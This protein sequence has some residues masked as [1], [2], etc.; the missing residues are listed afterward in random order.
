MDQGLIL[1]TTFLIDL[2][3]EVSRGSP[4]P[5][6]AFLQ[7]HSEVPL[8]ITFTVSGELAA[9][10]APTDRHKWERFVA[11]F[12]VLECTDAVA[13]TYGQACRYLQAHGLLIGANDLWI[14][15]TAI[16]N[17]KGLVTANEREYT[18]VPGL[19]V[20]SYRPSQRRR[21]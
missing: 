5:A 16:T 17:G 3:R 9:G 4:G 6:Q 2:E 10:V 21:R 12:H 15:A 14:A 11:P 19:R 13:W 1:E 18:R 7:Q 8:F 20:V